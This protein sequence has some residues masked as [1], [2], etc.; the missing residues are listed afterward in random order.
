MS[1]IFGHSAPKQ[2]AQSLDQINANLDTRVSGLN[3]KVSALDTELLDIRKKLQTARGPMQNSLKTR[4]MNL[5]KQKKMYEGQRDRIM[6]QQFGITQATFTTQTMQDNILAV[7][8]MKITNQQMKQQM[9]QLDVDKVEKM[10]DEMQD[11]MDNASDIQETMSRSYDIGDTVGDDELE[12]ELA[13]MQDEMNFE[14]A[15]YLDAALPSAP[16]SLPSQP[17]ATQQRDRVAQKY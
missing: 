6:Q 16:M 14:D 1:R 17:Q 15:S 3:T 13:S 4:A 9:K 10:R 12:A 2:P 7:E 8:A 11:L 5:L